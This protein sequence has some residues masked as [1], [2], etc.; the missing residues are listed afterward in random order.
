[1]LSGCRWLLTFWLVFVVLL[2][3]FCLPQRLQRLCTLSTVLSSVFPG[4]GVDSKRFHGDLQSVFETFLLPPIPVSA[5]LLVA[6]R[7]R[8]FSAAG[9]LTCELHGQPFVTETAAGWCGCWVGVLE[10]G[11]QCP[12][13]CP[14]T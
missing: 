5:Y 6:H 11:P 7:R 4:V 10:Q 13:S 9:G 14:A 8:V 2:Q 12:G 3:Q 1:M